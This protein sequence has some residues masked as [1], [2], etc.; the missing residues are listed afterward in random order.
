LN[1]NRSSTAN[2]S[3]SNHLFVSLTELGWLFH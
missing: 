2:L 1:P 3:L